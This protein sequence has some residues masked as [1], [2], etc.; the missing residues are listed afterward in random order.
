MGQ[1]LARLVVDPIARVLTSFNGSFFGTGCESDCSG[2]GCGCHLMARAK[3]DAENDDS[4]ERDEGRNDVD[5][6][7]AIEQ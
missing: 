6:I 4:E 7:H 3:G 5:S 2:P 1:E